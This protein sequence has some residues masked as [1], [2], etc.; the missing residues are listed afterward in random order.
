MRAAAP[1]FPTALSSQAP[2][3]APPTSRPAPAT[4][5]PPSPP[6][7]TPP[8]ISSWWGTITGPPQSPG[9]STPPPQS[10]HCSNTLDPAAAMSFPQ[11][12]SMEHLVSLLLQGGPTTALWRVLPE[13]SSRRQSVLR[14]QTRRGIKMTGSAKPFDAAAREA[15][16]FDNS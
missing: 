1:T 2:V 11:R 13:I 5:A 6:A 3:A 9:R 14:Q 12:R 16:S 8:R 7:P 10:V 15:A 4:A